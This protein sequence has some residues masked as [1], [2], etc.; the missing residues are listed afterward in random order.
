MIIKSFTA[1][2]AAAALK[3]VRSEMGGDA[4]VLKTRELGGRNREARVEITAC[5]DKPSVAQTSNIF[6]DRKPVAAPA[7]PEKK[8]A[9]VSRVEM[10][11]EAPKQAEETPAA[12]KAAAEKTPAPEMNDRLA[13]LEAKID[14]LVKRLNYARLDARKSDGPDAELYR[15]LRDADFPED[16]LEELFDGL[17]NDRSSV[18]EAVGEQLA[19]DLAGMIEPEFML[20]PGSRVLIYGPAGTGKSSVMGKLAARLVCEKKKVKLVSLDNLKVGAF[21]ELASYADLLGVDTVALNEVETSEKKKAEEITLMDSPAMPFNESKLNDFRIQAEQVKPTHRIAVLSSLMC[22][23]DI[24]DM[25]GKIKLFDPTHLAVTMTDI[26]TRLGSIVTACRQLGVKLVYV[27][28]S[29]AGVGRIIAPSA[30]R[31]I[32]A[33]LKEEVEVEQA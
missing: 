18:Y 5:L 22:S 11:V 17:E 31:I 12:V 24:A 30:A 7:R 13:G 29:P 4:V 9:P 3:K 26:T 10:P 14:M 21:E 15:K 32:G 2:S 8:S 23:G 6:P 1:E 20:E 16:Y 28:D 33:A 27:T 19:D 25:A